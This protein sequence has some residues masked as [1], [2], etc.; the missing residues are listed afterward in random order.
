MRE[1]RSLMRKPRGG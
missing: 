1:W